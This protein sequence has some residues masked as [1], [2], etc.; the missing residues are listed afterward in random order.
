MTVEIDG[1]NNII[2]TNTISEVTS[3]NGVTVDGL[4]IKDSKLVT[5]NSVITTNIT[6]ANVTTAKITDANVTQGKIADQAINEAKMQISNAPTNGYALTAQSSNTGGMTWASVG[7]GK[8][9]QI[10]NASLGSSTNTNSSSVSNV[11]QLSFTPTSSSS[12]VAVFCNVGY[13]LFGNSSS[14]N[15]GGN[16]IIRKEIGGSGSDIT[17]VYCDTNGVLN[18]TYAYISIPGN[19][20]G[21]F[22]P[23]A[24]TQ[25]DIYLRFKTN[26]NGRIQAFGNAEGGQDNP[27]RLIA[28]EYST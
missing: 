20:N 28:M 19:L 22:T 8:V 16:F 3:A 6:D 12:V 13:Q 24:T 23:G 11:L 4:N 10:V 9:K 5:A 14:S 17:A 27:T 2:K 1:A 21:I 18:S 25:C 15:P 26:G 7:G